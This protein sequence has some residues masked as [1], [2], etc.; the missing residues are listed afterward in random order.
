MQSTHTLTQDFPSFPDD[1]DP[2][3][4]NDDINDASMMDGIEL[5]E[6]LE[7]DLASTH[8]EFGDSPMDV[9][10][11]AANIKQTTAAK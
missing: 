11:P 4:S 8:V 6:A 3:V 9:S 7:K 5:Y 2:F 1:Y 10:A